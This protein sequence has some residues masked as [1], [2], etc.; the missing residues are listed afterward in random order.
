MQFFPTLIIPPLYFEQQRSL[1]TGVISSGNPAGAMIYSIMIQYFIDSYGWRATLALL[2]AISLNALALAIIIV[3]PHTKSLNE[4]PPSKR[5]VGNVGIGT[6]SCD[7]RDTMEQNCL[8]KLCKFIDLPFF[9]NIMIIMIILKKLL[10]H[11]GHIVVLMFLPIGTA[12][13]NI[14]TTTTA[15][16]MSL[17]GFTGLAGRFMFGMLGNIHCVKSI[18]LFCAAAVI[19][20][21]VTVIVPCMTM[22][23]GF[24]LIAGIFGFNYGR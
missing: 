9:K 12:E 24:Y 15:R 5:R 20:G 3:P 14:D 23:I 22:P 13:N 2:G 17:I 4:N 18:Y 11:M 7:C 21:L 19:C 8:S 16:I 10:F 6:D 1:V